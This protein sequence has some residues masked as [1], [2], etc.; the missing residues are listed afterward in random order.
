[1]TLTDVGGTLT[2]V[3]SALVAGGAGYKLV[4]KILDLWST[5]DA[6]TSSSWR[7]YA[8]KMEARLAITEAE[9]DELRSA[10]DAE[11]RTRIQQEEDCAKR[12]RDLGKTIARL[13]RA[14]RDEG[15]VVPGD[16]PPRGSAP[17][18]KQ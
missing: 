9:I 14:G 6:R 8:E 1:M 12:I 7:E 16:T 18:G 5:S 4:E 10:L 2:V 3:L 17:R 11:R 13:E 15:G